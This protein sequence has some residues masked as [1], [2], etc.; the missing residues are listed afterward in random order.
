MDQ[1]PHVHRNKIKHSQKQDNRACYCICYAL[2]CLFISGITE[3][4]PSSCGS[5]SKCPPIY[6]FHKVLMNPSSWAGPIYIC[7]CW[8]FQ[9]CF[10]VN[11]IPFLPLQ[12]RQTQ[13]KVVRGLHLLLNYRVQISK[14]LMICSP[15]IQGT[16]IITFG[17]WILSWILILILASWA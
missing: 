12:D 1:V 4:I 6:C 11:H 15:V 7:C 5:R 9:F 17:I 14:L 16:M 3:R 8:K 10:R 13:L 2:P